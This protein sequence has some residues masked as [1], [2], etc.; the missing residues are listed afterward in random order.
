MMTDRAST[1]APRC[2]VNKTGSRMPVF[3]ISGV[4]VI[5]FHFHRFSE[6][7]GDARIGDSRS[8]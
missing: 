7:L 4:E 5:I 6:R 1:A 3:G 2:L 8:I